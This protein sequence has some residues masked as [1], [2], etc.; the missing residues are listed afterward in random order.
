MPVF[1]ALAGLALN[2]MTAVQ[3]AQPPAIIVE[4]EKPRDEAEL[5]D[6]AREL[7]GRPRSDRPLAR[8]EQPLCLIVAA[9]DTGLAKDIATRIIAN[10]RAA[11]VRVRAGGCK[12]NALVTLSD[13]A[14]AQLKQIRKSGRQ[15]FAGLSARELDAALQT[16][17]PVY[18]FQAS[19]TTAATGQALLR[20]DPAAAPVGKVTAMGRLSRMT[21]KDMLAALV[22]VDSVATAGLTSAQLADY[23]T[24]R[25]LAP[26][27]E[28]DIAQA[29]EPPTIMTLFAAPGTAPAGLSRFD[30][31][32][33]K[34]LYRMPPGAFASDVLRAAALESGREDQDES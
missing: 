21:R 20:A 15:L 33:L 4:G 14:L 26:T 34:A 1:P 28:V 22:V 16:R 27:G 30:R 11:K 32:Y 18:V 13:D 7:A 23:T 29:D 17:D 31:A 10:A 19:E 25:L 24:L 5:T 6:L 8:F 2:A 3:D 9:N 12:P